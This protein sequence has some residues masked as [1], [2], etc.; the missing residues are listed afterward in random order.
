M[1]NKFQLKFHRIKVLGKEFCD[2]LYF[3][4]STIKLGMA[5]K[6]LYIDFTSQSRF[7]TSHNI[8]PPQTQ[9]TSINRS[10]RIFDKEA[11]KILKNCSLL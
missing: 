7:V 5:G 11:V 1:E 9:V 2:G 3:F 6:F 10:N 8:L 4:A